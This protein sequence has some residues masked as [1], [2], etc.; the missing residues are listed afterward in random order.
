M[1]TFL[2][3]F[4]YISLTPPIVS[5]FDSDTK[6]HT[7]I[8]INE[9]SNDKDI[10]FIVNSG[11]TKDNEI[12]TFNAFFV[13]FDCPKE[14]NNEYASLEKVKLFKEGVLKKLNSFQLSPTFIIN[15]RNG[16]HVY[17]CL[18]K[19]NK[20]Q[21]QEWSKIEKHIVNELDADPKVCNPSR[22]MRVPFTYWNK[23]KN[24]PFFVDIYKFNDIRY[25][26]DEIKII[27]GIELTTFCKHTHFISTNSSN[28]KADISEN[29]LAIKN[30]DVNRTKAIIPKLSFKKDEYTLNELFSQIEI[31]S[32][33]GIDS[34]MFHCILPDHNDSIPS[35]TI[36]ITENGIQLYKCFGCNTSFN[37]AQI[38]QKLSSCSYEQSL[39]FLSTIYKIRIKE[40]EKIKHNKV[41]IQKNIDYLCSDY[42]IHNNPYTYKMLR[43]RIPHFIEILNI[44]MND[45]NTFNDLDNY[46]IFWASYNTILKESKCFKCKNTISNTLSLLALLGILVKMEDSKIPDLLLERAYKIAN[47]YHFSKR[48]NFF[49]II[50]LRQDKLLEVENTAKELAEKNITLSNLGIEFVLRSFSNEKAKIVFPQHHEYLHTSKTSNQKTDNL[51]KIIIS[52]IQKK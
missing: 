22:K 24:S 31:N 37:I 8:Q 30:L 27:L 36:F 6:I 39:E 52:S 1:E 15:T 33:I 19:N 9:I 7:T 12:T 13:D 26:V 29:I 2:E 10:F 4:N 5:A 50:P 44:A 20:I 49:Q 34:K 41:I 28:L 18:E 40:L 35:A 11:G 38:I 45:A 3:F 23:D 25:S 21:K 32:F 46:P 17:W 48:C 16:Y 47:T 51:V 43:K 42:F 14:R